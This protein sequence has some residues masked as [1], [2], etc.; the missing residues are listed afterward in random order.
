MKREFKKGTLIKDLVIQDKDEPILIKPPEKGTL[1]LNE[2]FCGDYSLWFIVK[3]DE[4]GN[5][6]SRYNLRYVSEFTYW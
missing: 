6:L 5:E 2:E 3:K 4:Q 1:V